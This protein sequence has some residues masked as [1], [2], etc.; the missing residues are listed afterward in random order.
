MPKTTNYGN[1][2]P[3]QVRPV[4]PDFDAKPLRNSFP[5]SRATNQY[6][7][8]WTTSQQYNWIAYNA[9]RVYDSTGTFC[10]WIPPTG[11][12]FDFDEDK[13]QFRF[14]IDGKKALVHVFTRFCKSAPPDLNNNI[15]SLDV[16]HLCHNRK[17]CRPSHLEYE[18]RDYNKS[19]DNC[20]GYLKDEHGDFRLVC[21]HNPP[22]KV[23]TVVSDCAIV[24][25]IKEQ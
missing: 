10:C 21:K 15:S 24:N 7:T 14:S 1:Y 5:T 16:S 3:N 20:P 17:C 12:G 9:N 19:R 22:C 25:L 18:G 4:V 6:S 11:G 23:V 13:N 2:H 8:K